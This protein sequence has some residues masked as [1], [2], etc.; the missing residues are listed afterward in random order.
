MLLKRSVSMKMKLCINILTIFLLLGCRTNTEEGRIPDI[1]SANSELVI[2]ADY[3]SKNG[4]S[5]KKKH[6][7]SFNTYRA[8][9]SALQKLKADQNP[10]GSWGASGN[11]QLSTAL[12]LISFLR[13]GETESSLDYGKAVKKAHLWLLSSKPK[14]D[15]ELIATAVALSDYCTFNYRFTIQ[16]PYSKKEL[17][18]I[19]ETET[20]KISECL[21]AISEDCDTLW[22]DFLTIS[23]IPIELKRP[24]ANN[25]IRAVLNKY[26]KCKFPIKLSSI[27]D[28]MLFYLCV[29]SRHYKYSGKNKKEWQKIN[30]QIVFNIKDLQAKDGLFTCLPESNKISATGL[31]IM[32]LGVYYIWTDRFSP[33]IPPITK[34]SEELGLKIE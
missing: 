6:G 13:A 4:P 24:A 1:I 19:P 33:Y 20:K 16:K 3:V 32:N 9:V 26:S 23:R 31:Y 18:P 8:T 29:K 34:E 14:T 7:E 15:P 28:F 25:D 11:Q 21:T 30:K 22:K 2:P 5:S 27:N 12:A 10:D 17:P